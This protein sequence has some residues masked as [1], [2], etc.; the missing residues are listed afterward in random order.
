M[1]RLH[2]FFR[3]SILKRRPNFERELVY[4]QTFIENKTGGGRFNS[5]FLKYGREILSKDRREISETFDIPVWGFFPS[6]CEYYFEYK[7]NPSKKFKNRMNQL[8]FLHSLF[9]CA[10]EIDDPFV[11]KIN[12][13]I[14]ELI[15]ISD[16]Y[17]SEIESILFTNMS[18]FY[19]N[20]G[21]SAKLIRL[22][23]ILIKR[24]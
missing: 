5:E 3:R 22:R 18:W 24:S 15:D 8:W 10:E 2:K 21:S 17:L 1:Q 16:K 23:E 13:D 14:F 19:S 6:N 12:A 20:Y 7:K 4:S 9:V 11:H